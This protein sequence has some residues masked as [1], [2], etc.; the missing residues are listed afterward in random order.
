MQEYLKAMLKSITK[1]TAI[2]AIAFI[3]IGLW[4]IKLNYLL[5]YGLGLAIALLNFIANSIITHYLI[6][7]RNNKQV[8]YS[9]INFIVRVLIIAFIALILFMYNKIYVI[10]YII[11]Y[12]THFAAIIIYGLK[13]DKLEG[14]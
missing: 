14:K 6:N 8:F 4:F 7:K 11:G 3:A 2:M 9:L 5:C 1:I 10:A 12:I 13:I